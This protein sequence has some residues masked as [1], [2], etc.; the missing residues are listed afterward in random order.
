MTKYTLDTSCSESITGTNNVPI[1]AYQV[2][3]GY[4]RG[5]FI[6]SKKN[7]SEEGNCEVIDFAACIE[8]S[9]IKNNAIISGTAIVK[10][11]SKIGG[12]ARVGNKKFMNQDEIFRDTIISGDS[13]IGGDA[14]IYEGIVHNSFI[15]GSAS[16]IAALSSRGYEKNSPVGVLNCELSGNVIFE[17]VCLIANIK[18]KSNLI[19]GAAAYVTSDNDYFFMETQNLRVCVYRTW[20]G[21]A[22]I[23][24]QYDDSYVIDVKWEKFASAPEK[25]NI[26]YLDASAAAMIIEKAN[27]TIIRRWSCIRNN[28]HYKFK[29]L[30][31]GEAYGN[32]GECV[33]SNDSS[34]LVSVNGD[35]RQP[36]E[37]DLFKSKTGNA[38][39]GIPSYI[40]DQAIG[41]LFHN[42]IQFMD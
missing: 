8:N 3:Y 11:N 37:I 30:N 23:S 28:T 40:I 7:L 27:T 14:G 32:F 12:N 38:L 22:V 17:R 25:V 19:F 9:E 5:G 36:L 1:T 41:A 26:P 21:E 42:N 34:V 24:Y 20:H 13:I 18:S 15:I 4:N 10:G 16:I 29:I 6:G 2:K 33:A 35:L 31:L 39:N